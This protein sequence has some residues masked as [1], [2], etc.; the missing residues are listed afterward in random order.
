MPSANAYVSII[1]NA[2]AHIPIPAGASFQLTPEIDHDNIRLGVVITNWGFPGP[3]NTNSRRYYHHQFASNA[4]TLTWPVAGV[5]GNFTDMY[6]YALL[7]ISAREPG[8][9]SIELTI[10]QG[11]GEAQAGGNNAATLKIW[12]HRTE[13]GDPGPI[14]AP[15]RGNRINLPATEIEFFGGYYYSVAPRNGNNWVVFIAQGPGGVSEIELDCAIHVIAG[16]AGD[17]IEG[18]ITPD[19]NTACKLNVV[20]TNANLM[21]MVTP[22][23]SR[24]K[25][26]D[27]VY[28]FELGDPEKD[29][30]V[31]VRQI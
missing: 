2:V 25:D 1:S 11:D 18:V 13:P 3:P 7:P 16:R 20:G 24:N 21:A 4:D 30:V 6:I 22:K 8:D 28:T 12:H 29:G 27:D 26:G 9:G 31:K 17:V 19:Q 14:E 10:G 5:D 23:Y 15:P